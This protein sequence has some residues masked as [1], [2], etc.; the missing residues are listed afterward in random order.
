MSTG[1]YIYTE[2]GIELV[3]DS[4]IYLNDHARDGL[5]RGVDAVADAVKVTLGA[6]GANAVLESDLNPGHLVTNDG[7]S[8]ARLVRLDDPIENIGA[9][10]IKEVANRSD[11]EGGDGTTTTTVLTQAILHAG[12]TLKENPMA[13]KRSLDA[14]IPLIEEAL[15]EQKRDI[16]AE[17]I[18]Q[19]ATISAESEEMGKMFQDIY[20]EIG[21]D[22]IIELDNSNLPTTFYEVQ[23]G[24]RLRNAGW[25]GQ[26]SST[27]PGKAIYKK[28]F[29]V[30]AKDKIQSVEEIEPIMMAVKQLG[31]NELVIWADDID[32]S[33]ANRL[34][35]THLQ[36]GFKTLIIKAPTLWKDLIAEDFAKI[37]G[38]TIVE[39]GE[40]ISFKTLRME[41]LG[42]CEKIITTDKETRVIGIKDI[43]E[44]LAD[45]EKQN[46]DEAKLRISWLKTRVATLKLGAQSETELAYKRLK[47]E[48]ARNAAYQALQEGIIPGGGVALANAASKMP[49]TIGGNILKKALIAPLMQIIENAGADPK[50]L[51]DEVGFGSKGFNAKSL[52]VVDMWEAGI[53]DP[54]KVVKTAVKNAISVAGTVL[55]A[56]VA[57]T[58][59]RAPHHEA[60]PPMPGM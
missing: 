40:G 48:D 22:G 59:P 33:V 25:L 29:I 36:G 57:V 56:R 55:T 46:T 34:A 2:H 53:V 54:A 41:H 58:L 19:V 13:V 44:H 6:A 23:E 26:Y 20:K 21:K 51:G 17:E 16:T 52:E 11:K 5:M 15:D 14:C 32:L 38:A 3:R 43:T 42:T 60:A 1:K 49:D 39:S 28:P 37:T 7:V 24:V 18:L 47:A 50:V 45:L 9:N 31:K 27:Q 30:I 4:N 12:I 8:I 35:A 10:L